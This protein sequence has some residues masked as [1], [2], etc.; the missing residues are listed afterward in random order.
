MNCCNPVLAQPE[1]AIWETN[2][3]RFRAIQ[4]SASCLNHVEV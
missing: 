4:V 1:S 2:G 3:A